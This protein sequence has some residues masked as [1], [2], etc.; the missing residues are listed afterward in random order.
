MIFS[1]NA[2]MR[3]EFNTVS[4]ILY[5]SFCSRNPGVVTFVKET[6]TC[7][8]PLVRPQATTPPQKRLSPH[9]EEDEGSGSDSDSSSSASSVGARGVAF[10]FS[11]GTPSAFTDASDASDVSEEEEEEED[12]GDEADEEHTYPEEDEIFESQMDADDSSSAS[13]GESSED[14]PE[15]DNDP[16]EADEEIS[17]ILESLVEQGKSLDKEYPESVESYIGV[18][19]DRDDL[20]TVPKMKRLLSFNTL[21]ALDTEG[22]HS[23]VTPKRFKCSP[24]HEFGQ[25]PSLPSLSLGPA[26][27][28]DVM[29]PHCMLQHR[30]ASPIISSSDDEY[31]DR[32]LEE[33]LDQQSDDDS[34]EHTPVPLL[35]PPQSPLTFEV[36]GETATVCEWPSNLAVDS[37]M[38]SARE[39]QPLTS[40][41]LRDFQDEPKGRV[42][43]LQRKKQCEP[44]TLLTPILRGISMGKQ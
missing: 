32:Q 15:D 41:A 43:A 35:T 2:L 17:S 13:D 42:V 1:L 20:I 21:A 12:S 28:T 3:L 6:V 14:E 11:T 26:A 31:L 5:L 7:G 25:P 37:A 4:H 8:L 38:A 36:D 33:E 39:L 19:E 9:Y 18:M 34:R 23:V 30:R 27:L 29:T 40:E 10:A 16:G 44:S 22:G 24:E